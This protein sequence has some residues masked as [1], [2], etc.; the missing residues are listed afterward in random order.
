MSTEK[1][2]PPST[3]MVYL[4][5]ELDTNVLT[6]SV[7]RERLAEIECL[8][9]HWL[10]KKTTTKSALQSLIGKVVFV[11]KCVRAESCVYFSDSA[12]FTKTQI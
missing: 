9:A 10:T 1:A 11:S 4:G 2:S 3:R 5:V 12:C 8:L 7:S 6:L